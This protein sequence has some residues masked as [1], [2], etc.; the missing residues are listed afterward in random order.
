MFLLNSASVS[1][2]AFECLNTPFNFQ[3][4]I[5][6]ICQLLAARMHQARGNSKGNLKEFNQTGNLR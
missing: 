2:H 3:V 6:G 4:R 1:I 5:E